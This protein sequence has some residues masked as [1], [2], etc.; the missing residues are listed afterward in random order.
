[1]A[2]RKA[3]IIASKADLSRYQWWRKLL[4]AV[5]GAGLLVAS[6]LV[7]SHWEHYGGHAVIEGIGLCL[8]AV[9]ILGRMWC[10]LY[11]GGSKA[12][13]IVT[14]GPYSICRNPLY[15]FSTIA[16]AGIGAESGTL[17]LGLA[18][19]L[20]CA[21]AFHIVIA[22]EEGFLAANFGETYRGYCQTTP[23]FW[24]D[25]SA[26]KSPDLIEVRPHRLLMTLL[27]GLVFLLIIP[28]MEGIEHLQFAGI[29]KPLVWLY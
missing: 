15:L 24:P 6:G 25:L 18:Y 27:D 14:D 4:L 28:V 23:R 22:R 13:R 26:F 2:G 5:S 1:M 17:A 20:F 10:T 9:G 21:G 29:I 7:A 3:G 12:A 8:I 11:I 19:G 16:A